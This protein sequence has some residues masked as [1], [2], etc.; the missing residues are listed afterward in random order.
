MTPLRRIVSALVRGREHG[1]R[2]R[3]W[4]LVSPPQ[5]ESPPPPAPISPS[6]GVV[7]GGKKAKEPPK[8]VTPPD[9]F[10]VVLHKDSLSPGEITEVIIAGTAIA[11]C[12]VEGRFYAVSNTCPHAG[13]PIGEGKLE[14]AT[15]ACPYHGW[16]YDVRDGRCF[17]QEDIKL[18][19]YEVRVVGDAVCVRL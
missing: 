18:P 17:V 6:T 2:R 13:G 9:G 1:F 12:N 7:A 19:T 14:G 15:V 16:T 3:F 11:L 5:A 4:A 8:A 10:E